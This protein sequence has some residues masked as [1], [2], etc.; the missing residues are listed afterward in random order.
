[1]PALGCRPPSGYDLSRQLLQAIECLAGGY[2]GFFQEGRIQQK[3]TAIY[4][5]M[6]GG[7]E[8]LTPAPRRCRSGDKF[9][10]QL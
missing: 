5:G 7:L 1:M 6:I 10:I 8:G 4:E 3:S 9:L 2:T